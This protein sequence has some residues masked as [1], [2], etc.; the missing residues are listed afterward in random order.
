MK[1]TGLRNTY[2]NMRDQY[3][4]KGQYQGQIS[5]DVINKGLSSRRYEITNEEDI[6]KILSQVATDIVS[7]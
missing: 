4:C 2:K 7:N 3:E 6:T 1:K 5:G